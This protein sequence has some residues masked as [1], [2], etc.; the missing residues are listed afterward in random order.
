MKGF[1]T[2]ETDRFTDVVFE[3]KNGDSFPAH[4]SRLN[5]LFTRLIAMFIRLWVSLRIYLSTILSNVFLYLLYSTI[6]NTLAMIELRC[7]SLLDHKD[8]LRNVNKGTFERFL[9]Y[10]YTDYLDCE[11]SMEEAKQ[12]KILA[13]KYRVSR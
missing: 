3:L 4:T 8:Y 7:P 13:G 5:I 2:I 1:E 12:L 11:L 9:K 10:I 6:Y